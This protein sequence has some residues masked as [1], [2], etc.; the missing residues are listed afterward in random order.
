MVS[1]PFIRYLQRRDIPVVRCTDFRLEH[2]CSHHENPE[3]ASEDIRIGPL[4]IRK[5]MQIN[6]PHVQIWKF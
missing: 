6:N 3:L 2:E 4:L 1:L 5:I